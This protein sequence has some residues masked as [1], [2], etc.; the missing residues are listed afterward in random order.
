MKKNK[1]WTSILEAI[2]V[3]LIITL[4]VIWIFNIFIKSQ[5]LAN[6]AENK[7]TA[8]LIAREWIEVVMNIRDTNW[9]MFQANIENC[10]NVLNYNSSCI[11]NS[12]TDIWTWSYIIYQDVDNK[13]YLSWITIPEN[14]YSQSNYRDIYAIK[15]DANWFYTQAWTWTITS[16]PFF[17][18]EIKVS[19]LPSNPANQ[20]MKVESIVRWNEPQSDGNK[21][22]V[23]E[24]ILTNW[25]KN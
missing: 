21:E 18:R 6:Q 17:T 20:K 8:T 9:K 14:S 11:T 12:S 19:Y 5:N 1:K 16:T 2:V 25:K 23:L 15:V 10:W 4:G 7:L 13:W 22:L 24:S 3:I